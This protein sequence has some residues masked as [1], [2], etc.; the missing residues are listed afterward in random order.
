MAAQSVFKALQKSVKKWAKQ[1]DQRFV[2]LFLLFGFVVSSAVLPSMAAYAAVAEDDKGAQAQ[3]EAAD[4]TKSHIKKLDE[5]VANK[6]MK[7]NYPEAMPTTDTQSKPAADYTKQVA[8][9]LP[10]IS[11]TEGSV[12][13]AEGITAPQAKPKG[14]TE[15]LTDKRT[16]TSETLRNADGSLTQKQYA[17]PKFFKKDNKWQNIDT[18]LI[19]DKNT[20]DSGNIF[21]KAL[22]VVESWIKPTTS[23]TVKA[24]D[25]QARFLPSDDQAGMVRIKKG[26][27]Q[28]AYTPTNAKAG[29]PP[30][31]TTDNNG[32]QTVH[33]Y[34]LWPGVNVE[35]VVQA[36]ELKENIIL[37]D[38]NAT[39]NFAFTVNG[40]QLKKSTDSA[41][42]GLLYDIKGAL[43]DAFAIAPMTISLN[44]YGFEANQ[45]LT[46]SYE[47]NQLKIAVDRGYLSN[48]PND[49]YPV[50]IDPTTVTRSPFGS[51]AGGNYLSFKSDGFVCY[52]NQCNPLA[53]SVLDS[54]YYWQAWRSTFF[55]DY[56]FLKGRQLTNANLHLTQ[57]LGLNTSG[58]T[59]AKNIT[60]WHA[61]CLGFDCR[62]LQGNTL[63][64]GTVGDINVTGLYQAMINANDWG[65][66]MM[67]T[68][69]ET[70]ATTYKNMDPDYSYVEFSYNDVLPAPNVTS[71]VDGQMYIDPQVSFK[72]A[73]VTNPVNGGALQYNFC[74]S[75]GTSCNGAVM[76]SSPQVAP[77]WTIPDGLLQDGMTYYIQ[78]QSYDPT[79]PAYSSW[80]VPVFFRIDSRTGKDSTQAYDTLGPVSADL[81]SGNVSTSVSSHVISAL[82]GSL[83][84]SLDYNS[85]LKSR[86]GLVGEYWN[87]PSGYGGGVPSGS[88]S[89]TRVDQTVDFNWDQGSPSTGVIGNDNYFARWS[90]YF[91]APTTGTFY[92]G[93]QV[94][95]IMPVYVNNNDVHNMPASGTCHTVIC[96]GDGVSLTTGQVIPIRAEFQEATGPAFAKLYV[97][98]A[99]SEQVVKAEWLQTGVRA[100]SQQKGLT[101]RYYKDTGDH[102]FNNGANTMIMQRTDPSVSFDWGFNAAVPG[103]PTDSFM[104]RWTGYVTAPTTGNYQFGTV[105]DD[106]T[107]I[108]I[109]NND[110]Q[111]INKWGTDGGTPVWSG[112]YALTAGQ[113]TKITID[114]F[115][116]IGPAKMYLNIRSSSLGVPEQI[117]PSSWLSSGAQVLPSGWNLGIDPDGNVSYDHLRPTANS[118]IL[119]DSTGSTHEYV[120]DTT[121]NAYKPPVN[122]DGSL[123]RNADATYTFQDTDGR[124]YIFNA[125][126]TVNSITNP[127]DDAKPAALQ[128]TY[129]GTPSRLTQITDGVDANRWA[130][131]YYSGDSNCVVAPTGFD[132][133]A[134]T[135][136]LCAVKTNDGRTTAFFYKNGNLARIQQPGN[137]MTDYQYDTLGRIIA[138]RDPLANDAIAAGVRAN[139]GTSNTT[140]AYDSLGRLSSVTQPAPTTG[141]TRMQHTIA[142]KPGNGTYFGA[143]EQHVVGGSELMGFT[144]RIEYDSLLRTLKD[145]DIANLSDT[146]EWDPVKDLVLSTTDETGL[147]STTIYDDEDRVASKY[148]PAPT[149][150]YGTDRKPLS[151]YAG[152]VPRTDTKYDEGMQGP[153]VA[154]YNY[155]TNA[156]TLSGA[157]KLHT[158]NVSGA[159]AGDLSRNFGTTTPIPGAPNAD[160]WGFRATGRIRLPATGQYLFRVASDGGVRLFIDDKVQLDDWNDGAYRDHPQVGYENTAGSVHRFRLEYFHGSGNGNA[161]ITLYMTPP[162]GTETA[163]NVNQYISPDYSLTTSTK[164]YDSTIGDTTTTTSYGANP[165]LGLAQSTSVDATGLNLTTANAYEV[166]GATGSFLRQTSKAL[167]GNSTSNPSFAYAYYGATETRDNPCTTGVTEAYK[168]A[169]MLKIKTEADPDGSG[170]LTGRVTETIYD[171][172]GKIVASR[173]NADAWT[174]TTYD[175]R[176]R[177]TQTDIPAYNGAAARTETNN[178]A[179][180]GNPLTTSV[181]DDQGSIIT[182]VDV[183]GRTTSYTNSFGDVT[184]TVYDNF[185]KVSS[186]TSPRGTVSYTYDSYNRL[187]QQLIDSTVYA[188]PHYD[189]YSRLSSVDYPNANNLKAS[190]IGYDIFGRQNGITYTYGNGTTTIADS[191][192]YS[193]SGQIISGTE[194]GLSKAYTYDKASRLTAATIGTHTFTYDY[195][196]ASC[197][198]ADSNPNAGKNANRKS[199]TKDGVTINYCYNYADQLQ[200]S[201]DKDIYSPLYDTHGN[202]TRLGSNWDGGTTV[203]AFSYDSS[204]RI[205]QVNQNYGTQ[206]TSYQH[207]AN[208]RVTMRW[209][210]TNN[211]FADA[212]WY[213]YTGAADSA[214]YARNQAWNITEK[215]YQLPGG[216]EVT[217]RPNATPA[218]VQKTYSL[219]NIHGDVMA[220]ADAT[221]TAIAAYSYGPNGELLSTAT[222]NNTAA[223]ATFSWVGKHEKLTETNIKLAPILM[224]ARVY[225]PTLGRFL[226]IDPIAGGVENNYVYPPDPV[227]DFDLD[228]NISMPGW[229][230]QYAMDLVN[231]SPS[232]WGA[233][234][235]TRRFMASPK[236]YAKDVVRAGA[237]YLPVGKVGSSLGSLAY[238][239]KWLGRTSTLFGAKRLGATV[240]GK[241][242]NNN[243]VRLGWGVKG[244]SHIFRVAFG[245]AKQ[246]GN[247]KGSK[248]INLLV[249]RRW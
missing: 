237:M 207:D 105:G 219:P 167:P 85:P 110:T 10:G 79:I 39:A 77:Q 40:A 196:T 9:G 226:S 93:S 104:M 163:T 145:S 15:E 52:S 182:Q 231:Y 175:T 51:R 58:T 160:N 213:M 170:P 158:T 116:A 122:E 44:K 27:S 133:Q 161:N 127:V 86:N 115:E 189:T 146:T 234:N 222:P 34:D 112:D 99:V 190:A 35:Y 75:T 224:G 197:S 157:P 181:T 209:L 173:Y 169:G 243:T 141:S 193:Q 125:D 229:A 150:W 4:A 202:T 179:V 199:M 176:E 138:L 191:V 28:I 208:D 67:L 42:T 206:S 149:A 30:V 68:G 218:A 109:G 118:I 2:A 164:T 233:Y 204:D 225:I 151:T 249:R 177:I 119:S 192:S 26:D 46:Q 92:F 205:S 228:G 195:G 103:G 24:N 180:S 247:S 214:D 129:S 216:I 13:R 148:G 117:V 55:S 43:G 73:T 6:P 8:T 74:V 7:Q 25:W 200:W 126:G 159:A 152:Q 245:K 65:A 186:E 134:P 143:T 121:K 136:M 14:K 94:D 31:I 48:L 114:Y 221:G 20:G 69:E 11:T 71:T 128:Y 201:S 147:K 124:T 210:N 72:S 144:R 220:T 108:T 61:D 1:Q 188:V 90:G 162:G 212:Q 23:Y 241:L 76:I 168:Q 18:G 88:P 232:A 107:R 120:W 32:R 57:R 59:A 81:A 194:N 54:N 171:D 49:A 246:Y 131:V 80:G 248:H 84:V 66:W 172:A 53:G 3:T 17:A 174:C 142:Y 83:G 19:E 95:D 96:Y 63:S 70:T 165:E 244:S 235:N 183:L 98:G 132:A 36:A 236:G 29:V 203:T 82:G 227:G 230:K 111:I 102:D 139:D 156:K 62:G 12:T 47:N 87:V 101:G 187:S 113:P 41:S 78:V 106:G 97:K 38:K 240:S 56:S 137:E 21:G 178:Y 64:M 153:A 45:P 238:H 89:M 37:K 5:T 223:A 217:I 130:K 215:Y 155:S 33:Y 198:G 239:S 16:A 184:T 211:T 100:T 166:Q 22:G 154:Y 140:L 185:G 50:T 60:A 123:V 242:N 135:G 91:V